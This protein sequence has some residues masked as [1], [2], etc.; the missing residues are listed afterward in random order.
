MPQKGQLFFFHAIAKYAKLYGNDKIHCSWAGMIEDKSYY[1]S[2]VA[3]QNENSML[4]YC[5]Y[6]GEVSDIR[7][8]LRNTDIV[9]VCSEME[10]FGRVTVE[11]MLAGTIVLGADTGATTELIK[12]GENG[13]LYRSHDEVSFTNK[14][15]QILENQED[16]MLS[17][18]RGQTS[19]VEKY[20]LEHNVEQVI[21]LYNNIMSHS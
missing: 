17:A 11:S 9:V 7:T 13:Y 2:I 18:K 1:E 14:L 4:E 16:A 21:E 19:A 5:D 20:S 15:H 6:L 12:N 10:G 8:V 3:F